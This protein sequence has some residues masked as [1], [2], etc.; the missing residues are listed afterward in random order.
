MNAKISVFVICVKAI[1]YLLLYDLHDYA[2]KESRYIASCSANTQ[3]IDF[4]NIDLFSIFFF[5]RFCQMEKCGVTPH[6]LYHNSLTLSRESD[7]N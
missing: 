3:L 4:A 1:M 6:C 2:F 7:L 5:N